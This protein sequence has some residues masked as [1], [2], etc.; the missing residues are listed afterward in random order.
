MERV[1]GCMDDELRDLQQRSPKEVLRGENVTIDEQHELRMG[2]DAT[3]IDH[4]TMQD[5]VNDMKP[6]CVGFA[7]VGRGSLGKIMGE[8][9][10]VAENAVD[11]RNG[12]GDDGR[13]SNLNY[14]HLA[15]MFELSWW[16]N[17]MTMQKIVL[18]M[19]LSLLK[20]V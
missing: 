10:D 20:T 9:V 14:S 2:G 12:V 17:R 15:W 6:H 18:S 13:E 8:T 4:H 5:D 7:G 1:T 19:L 3:T 16:R 11:G